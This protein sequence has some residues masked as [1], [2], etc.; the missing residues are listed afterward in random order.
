MTMSGTVPRPLVPLLLRHMGM[1][2]FDRMEDVDIVDSEDSLGNFPLDFEFSAGQYKK[3]VV[4]AAVRV[5]TLLRKENDQG[6]HVLVSSKAVGEKLFEMLQPICNCRW[7]TSASTLEQQ[8]MIA[9]D[10]SQGRF[11]VLI[12]T[13]IALVG[14]EN[15]KCRHVVIVGYMYTLVNV[16]QAMGRLRPEQRQGG[17]SVGIFLPLISEEQLVRQQ[18]DDLL[19]FELLRQRKLIAEDRQL[20]T[21]VLTSRGIY[22]WLVVETGCRIQ[23]LARRIGQVRQACRICD[24]CRSRPTRMLAAAAEKQVMEANSLENRALLVLKR[25]GEKCL[26]CKRTTCDGEEC[27]GKRDCFCCGKQ[28]FRSTCKDKESAKMIL[29]NVGC[30]QCFDLY[31]R[32]GFSHHAF[33]KC[34]L[35][36][37]LRRLVFA[38]F[39]N[40]KLGFDQFLNGIYGSKQLFHAFLDSFEEGRS[41]K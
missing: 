3:S 36:R 10:W 38:R 15:G 28:H 30:F 9:L 22:D 8:T 6:I 11:E 41:Q 18:Q 17:A 2:Y 26:F 19:S 1:S 33:D 13:S 29:R 35:Q 34:P 25:L 4:A 24:A 40:S 32:R 12:S 14:N 31:G 7:V 20:H 16:I 27:M 37:R 39:S 23:N 21:R 5:E